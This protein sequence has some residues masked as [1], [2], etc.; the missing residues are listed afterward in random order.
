MSRNPRVRV[1]DG[2][3]GT[4]LIEFALILPFLLVIT[5]CVVDL[6]RAFY[7]KS[8]LTSAARDGA[9]LAASLGNPLTGANPPADNDAVVARVNLVLL[10]VTQQGTVGL[11][12]IAIAVTT[13]A[14]SHYK[15]Q[16]SGNFQWLY[17]GVLNFFGP[18]TFSN[19]QTLTANAVMRSLSST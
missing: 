13:P 10:P 15:V 3:R 5:L 14:A 2:Q 16:V 8:V 7:M 11:S 12:N 1:R 17:L 18:G 9:R 19:P 6:S 4:A